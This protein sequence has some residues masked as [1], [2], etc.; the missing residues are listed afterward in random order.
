MRSVSGLL[1]GTTSDRSSPSASETRKPVAANSPNTVWTTTE[2]N[3]SG[4]NSAAHFS[5]FSISSGVNRNGVG[6]LY[7]A[8]ARNSG[9][10]VSGNAALTYS[11][12]CLTELSRCAA[13]RVPGW[14]LASSQSKT[15]LDVIEVV[16]PRSCV[17]R[18]KSS[19]T[20]ASRSIFVPRPLR[21]SR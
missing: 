17:N 9:T 11:R 4:S 3:R 7:P 15:N 12:N 20:R 16:A 5:N 21:S 14:C 10:W 13:V 6:R 2:E 1:R 18:T 8:I 19:K